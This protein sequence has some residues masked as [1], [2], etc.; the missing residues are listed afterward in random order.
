MDRLII[1]QSAIINGKRPQHLA[2]ISV[3][4]AGRVLTCELNLIDGFRSLF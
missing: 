3:G 2:T 1:D 4:G